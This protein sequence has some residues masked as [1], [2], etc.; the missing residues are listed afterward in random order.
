VKATTS[1]RPVPVVTVDGRGVVSHAGT[2]LL[3]ELADRVGLTSEY[4]TALASARRR[5]GGHDPGQVAVDLAVTIADGGEVISDLRGLSDQA[6]V[7]GPVA[8]TATAWRLLDAVDAPVLAALRQAR[9]RARERAWAVRGELTGAELPGS[10]VAGRTLTHVVID[11]DA[12]LVTAH[13][14][15]QDAAPNYKGGFGYHPMLA[16]LDNTSEALAGILRPGNAGAN[17]AADHLKLLGLA[18]AQLPDHWRSKPILIR[19]DSAGA[20]HALLDELTELSLEYSIGYAVTA[21]VQTAIRAVP[22]RAWTAAITADGTLRDGADVTEITGMLNLPGWPAGMRVIVR[23][24]RPHPGAQLSLFEYHDGWRYQAFVT[25]TRLGQLSFLDARHR[26]H[27][28]VEDRI[29][30]GKACGIGKMPSQFAH[31]NAAWLELALTAADLLAWA[32]TGLLADQPGLARAEPRLLR[33]RLLHTTARLTRGSR[34]VWLRL[35]RD[36]PWAPALARAFQ[37][38]RQI[39]LPI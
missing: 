35:A 39:P 19:T 9:A 18:L 38:L 25:N 27:A 12:T 7:H 26:A 24:E 14:E 16:Y 5:G 33:Y 10:R 23:R 11:L 28:R 2:V 8:S 20:S 37:R 21:P 15:K 30:T 32:Q 34:R 1:G 3:R 31:V 4:S 22:A 17:D 36:W 6:L 29:R 13:S